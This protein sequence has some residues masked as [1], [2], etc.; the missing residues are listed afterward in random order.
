MLTIA[1]AATAAAWYH[2]LS[3]HL[4]ASRLAAVVGGGFCGFAPGMV[5]QATGHPNICGQ[6]LVPFIVLA[7]LK[8]RDTPHPVRV[9]LGLAGLVGYQAFLNEELLFL[10]ALALGVFTLVYARRRP[11][12][13][14]PWLRPVAIGLCAA[15]GVA[16]AVLA[17]PLAVQFFGPQAYHGLPSWV[18]IYGAYL[19]SYPAYP[20]QSVAGSVAGTALLAQGPTEQ[21]AFFGWG[22]CLLA[23]LIVRWRRNRDPRV[24]ALGVTA[25]VFALLSL[26]PVVFVHGQ[27]AWLPG[28]YRLV[29]WLPLFDSVVP[30]RFALVVTTVIGLL[31]AV[32]IERVRGGRTL[33][34]VAVALLPLV[35]V[36][37]R[38]TAAEPLPRFFASGHWRGYVPAGGTVFV[39][40][41]GHEPA[42]SAMRWQIR[43]GLRFRIVG[44]YFLGTDRGRT[45]DRAR[46]GAPPSATSTLLSLRGDDPVTVTADRAGEV[47][48]ELRNWR[49]DT[50][51]LADAAPQA[52]AV[53]STLEQVLGAGEHVDDVW[54]WRPVR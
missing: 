8:L 32:F 18:R 48:A 21:N 34:L 4:V 24:L 49:V 9:G 22:L 38:A 37:L 35:P 15:A 47:R 25:L 46:I 50:V 17:Y 19:G 40:P 13:V 42:L 53:R 7:V 54:V 2:V 23:V 30:T 36:P 43:T 20:Q 5:S 52:E 31:L 33:A 29:S 11:D 3:R 41:F 1:P 28:P 26:G 14:R 16:G 6:Y 12:L 10:T 51:L 39:A 44:G 45:G 27:T